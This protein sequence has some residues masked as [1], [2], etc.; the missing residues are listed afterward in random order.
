MHSDTKKRGLGKAMLI[1]LSYLGKFDAQII[2]NKPLQVSFQ[3]SFRIIFSD[4][5]SV[6]IIF[7]MYGRLTR[8]KFWD[9]SDT[10]YSCDIDGFSEIAVLHGDN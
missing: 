4:F 6:R 7:A 10:I 3:Q 1:V 5:L 8:L 9:S 2:T